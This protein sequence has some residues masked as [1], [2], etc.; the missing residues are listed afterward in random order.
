MNVQDLAAH[1]VALHEEMGLGRP[2]ADEGEYQ[3]AFEVIDQLVDAAGG[4]ESHAL[5]GLI[6]AAGDRVR[7]YENRAHPWPDR[8]SPASALAALMQ[9]HGL[10]QGDLLEVGSQGVVTPGAQL[11]HLP[12]VDVDIGL[13]GLGRQEGLAAPRG[14]GDT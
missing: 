1:G 8:S 6:A 2:I 10:R 9:E 14:A 7:E 5:W 4:D 11:G 3:R 12:L 13:D